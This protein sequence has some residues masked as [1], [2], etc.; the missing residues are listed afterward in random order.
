MSV[1]KD[2][3]RSVLKKLVWENYVNN[4]RLI[5]MHILNVNFLCCLMYI[6]V[7]D[8]HKNSTVVAIVHQIYNAYKA[9]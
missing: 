2:I 9:F 3:V 4:Y 6:Y 5:K 8:P 7:F 1:L